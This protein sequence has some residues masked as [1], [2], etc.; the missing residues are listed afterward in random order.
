[1]KVI[2][3]MQYDGI[4]KTLITKE[5]AYSILKSFAKEYKKRNRSQ[6]PTEIIIVGGGSILLNYGFREYT[7]DFD[8]LA[9][10]MEMIKSVSYQ[11]ADQYNLP[12]E[13]MNMDFVHTTSYSTKL[14]EVSKHFCSFNNGTLEFRTVNAEYL[15]AMKM[16]SAREYRNDMSDIVGILIF[17]KS[18]VK[19]FSMD[20]IDTAIKYLYDNQEEI[21]K[22]EVYDKVKEYVKCS[23]SELREEYKILTQTERETREKL[24]FVNGAYPGV[25]TEESINNVI[26]GLRRRKEG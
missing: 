5:N 25:V 26:A 8:I 4:D 21:I 9:Q 13:W 3:M 22:G 12:N 11:I 24:V 19:D 23:V 6:V 17:L 15:I 20:R 2:C 10:S 16:V 14:R 7:Q 1:M 18:D